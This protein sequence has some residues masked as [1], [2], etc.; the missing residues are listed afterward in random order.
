[1]CFKAADRLRENSVKKTTPPPSPEMIEKVRKLAAANGVELGEIKT[2]DDYIRAVLDA[3]PDEVVE[4][5]VEKL[6]EENYL[7]PASPR[8]N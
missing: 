8:L 7:R 6:E 3:L 1:M 5:A 2:E 4:K